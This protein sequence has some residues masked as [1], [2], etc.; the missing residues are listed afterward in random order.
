[1][2]T[3]FQLPQRFQVI[4]GTSSFDAG[5]RILPFSGASAVATVVSGKLVSK[6]KVPSIYIIVVGA[7]FQVIGYAFLGTLQPSQSIPKKIYGFQVIAGV[8]CAFSYSNLMMLVAFVVEKRDAAVTL[9][10]MNQF[11]GMGS[12]IGLAIVTS[13][14][15]YHTGSQLRKL[16]VAEPLTLVI[17]QPHKSVPHALQDDVRTIL[18]NG[19][20]QQMLTLC[21]FGAAQV[22]VA[23][24][25][26]K[27][28][29]LVAV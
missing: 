13:I 5:I 14:F 6:L 25:L 16:G 7:I 21:A 1:M 11:R 2:V 29:Q 28:K 26:W 19:Y 8:G 24:L 17:T 12:A 3:N 27:R 15:N 18:S 22:P 20:N 10:A 23:L 4:N 9:G